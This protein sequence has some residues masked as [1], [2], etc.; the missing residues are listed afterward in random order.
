MRGAQHWQRAATYAAVAHAGQTRKDGKTPF[1]SHPGRVATVV[2][3]VFGCSDS[4]ALAS[5]WL[6][7]TIEDTKTDYDEIAH[8]FGEETADCVAALTKNMLLPERKRDRD[9]EQRLARADWRARLVKLADQYDNYTDA[10]MMH[11]G[12]A[13][14][15]RRCRRM[16]DLA[17]KD[18][19]AHPETRRA[20]AALKAL[21]R[22]R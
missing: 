10:R 13:K 16:M 2:A 1:I 20:I 9:Y 4:I 21:M 19:K 7:D 18:A 8:L 6:H 12:L 22:S 3:A 15:A 17:R 11:R 14:A 5:A